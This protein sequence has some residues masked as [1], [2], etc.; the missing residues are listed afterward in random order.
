MVSPGIMES[1]LK[2]RP[3]LTGCLTLK[4]GQC[5]VG[6]L[7]GVVTSER[8]TE[9]SQGWLMPDGN[10]QGSAIA[11][12][13]LTVRHTGRSGT[14]VGYSDPVVP[15]GRAIAQRIKGTPGITG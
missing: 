3:W 6:S 7:T 12:A 11:E 1:T 5:L 8:V 13:S 10:R 14:K 15:H 2:Y 9:V 4:G